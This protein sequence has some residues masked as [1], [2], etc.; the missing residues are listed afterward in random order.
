MRAHIVRVL[1]ARSARRGVRV[2]AVDDPGT[3]TAFALARKQHGGR[4]EVR[5]GI[6]STDVAVA[7]EFEQRQIVSFVL[8]DAGTRAAYPHTG[9]GQ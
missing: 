4:R 7:G 8:L 6:N 3:R 1:R 9:N 2:A 5:L